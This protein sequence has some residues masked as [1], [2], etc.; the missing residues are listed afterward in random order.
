M[1]SQRLALVLT[2]VNLIILAA[3]LF[4]GQPVAAQDVTPVVRVGRFELVDERGTV[5]ASLRAESGPDATA[6]RIMDGTGAIR[7]KLAA[8]ANGSGLVLVDDGTELGVQ[9]LAQ[10]TGSLV[11]LV[12]RDGREH[13]VKP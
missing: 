3:L 12:D 13:V 4:R 10:E 6:L 8:D 2:A 1:K 9:M 5:R 7:V 11:K